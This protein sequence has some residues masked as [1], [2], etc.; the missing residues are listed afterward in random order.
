MLHC[1]YVTYIVDFVF[2]EEFYLVSCCYKNCCG[3]RFTNFNQQEGH[4]IRKDS[5]EGRTVVYM[6]LK[7]GGGIN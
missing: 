1:T 6:Y 3:A 4:K 2:S 5:P 7:G